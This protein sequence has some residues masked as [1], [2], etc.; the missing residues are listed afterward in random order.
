MEIK[1]G[2][3]IANKISSFSIVRIENYFLIPDFSNQFQ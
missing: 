3:V 2:V 1:F